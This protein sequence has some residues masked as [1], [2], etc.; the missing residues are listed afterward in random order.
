MIQLHHFPKTQ[1]LLPE[2]TLLQK[3][4]KDDQKFHSTFYRFTAG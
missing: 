1:E 4:E 2:G 3:A